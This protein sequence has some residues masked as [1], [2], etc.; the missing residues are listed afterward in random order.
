[1]SGFSAGSFVT[2]RTE[3]GLAIIAM[4]RPPVNALG[5]VLAG[6][7]AQAFRTVA[8]SP[9]IN[10][11]VLESGVRG[12]FMAGADLS[13]FNAGKESARRTAEEVARAFEA[14]ASL[15]AVT[16]AAIN[17]HALGGGLELA[18]CC[19][20]RYVAA[21]KYAL[22]LPEVTLGLLPGGGGTQRLPGLVGHAKALEWMIRGCRV[23][24][25][26]AFRAGLV[27]GLFPA[28]SFREEVRQVA[29]GMA[30]G[31]TVAIC[32]IKE[33]VR[34]TVSHPDATALEREREVFLSLFDT[35]DA[36]E[37]IRAFLA[38]ES[39]RFSGK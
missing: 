28:E 2:L 23:S 13:E 10:V 5:S 29:E 8:G 25:E 3:G 11:V 38:K 39:P 22:G 21:G 37:G 1:M 27:Q 31:A 19:D 35:A 34:S 30:S 20:L 24:P 12:F 4:A 33:L 32:A 26:E 9:G 17:G 16:I 18:L 15:K 36:R 14:L 6:E 7:L